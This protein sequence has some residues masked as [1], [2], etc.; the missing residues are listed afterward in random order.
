MDGT[1]HFMVDTMKL[2]YEE[3]LTSMI[4]SLMEVYYAKEQASCR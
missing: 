1:W 3:A 4:S 2:S